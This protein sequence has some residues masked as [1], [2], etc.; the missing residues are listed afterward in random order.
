MG[1]KRSLTNSRSHHI[2]HMHGIASRSETNEH[3]QKEEMSD[4]Y[5]GLEWPELHSFYYLDD[6]RSL[7]DAQLRSL[8]AYHFSQRRDIRWSR[9]LGAGKY[10]DAKTDRQP[11]LLQYVAMGFSNCAFLFIWCFLDFA[12]AANLLSGGIK[13]MAEC[14]FP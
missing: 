11:S 8:S 10:G 3:K 13:G 2:R 1:A 14:G 6:T 12:N 9:E 5:H 4:H 7:R